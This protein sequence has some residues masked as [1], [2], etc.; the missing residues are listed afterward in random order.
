MGFGVNNNGN[1]NDLLGQYL[2]NMKKQKPNYA[3][4]EIVNEPVIEDE[5][6]NENQVTA[7]DIKNQKMSLE[8]AGFTASIVVETIDI[9]FSEVL[10]T[11]AKL[12]REKRKEL[13]ADEDIKETYKD[14]WANYLKEKGTDI[15]PSLLLIILTLGIYAPKIPLAID[16]RRV[17]KENEE[18]SDRL[19]E[20]DRTI[21]KL[22]QQLNK[23]K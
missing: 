21:A 6:I 17:Q 15:P 7:E 19:E 1:Q 3:G 11:I 9:T 8:M 22:Q 18:L 2:D 20:K 14:A 16:M 5:N 10:G 23:R 4:D 12:D 13:K